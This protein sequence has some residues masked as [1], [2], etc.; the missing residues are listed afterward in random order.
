MTSLEEIITAV[1]NLP[2][3]EYRQF[4]QWFLKRDWVKR[5]RQIEA[6]SASGRLDFLAREAREAKKDG[7]L[8]IF[9]IIFMLIFAYALTIGNLYAAEELFKL[10]SSVTNKKIEGANQKN[11]KI[12][13]AII[14]EIIPL[15]AIGVGEFYCSTLPDDINN[16][17]NDP[18]ECFGLFPLIGAGISALGT[19]PSH[20]YAQT[21]LWEKIVF[22]MAKLA[23]GAGFAAGNG[24]KAMEQAFA[25]EN[26]NQD[27]IKPHSLAGEYMW[28]SI[29]WMATTIG[30]HL[31]ETG[32]Q[33]VSINEYNTNIKL[34]SVFL[35]PDLMKKNQPVLK[36]GFYF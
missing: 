5:D 6:D 4:R 36:V 20:I 32:A 15:A 22:P 25:N 14:G 3:K 9:S 23:V 11:K 28:I 1:S 24:I 19:L 35:Y 17:K 34:E 16:G 21:P 29:A 7:K 2:E 13:Y 30:F 10:D 27:Y 31:L 26:N 33:C 18:E 12:V 8:W